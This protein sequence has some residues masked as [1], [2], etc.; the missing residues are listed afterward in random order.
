MYGGVYDTQWATRHRLY[1]KGQD[2]GEWHRPSR[3][4][5][6]ERSVRVLSE[7]RSFIEFQTR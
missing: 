6:G 2:R 7:E 1:T 4:V 5:W 3:I